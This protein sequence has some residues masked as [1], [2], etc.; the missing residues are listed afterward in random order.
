MGSANQSVRKVDTTLLSEVTNPTIYNKAVAT[1]NTEVSQVL[2]SNVK[3]F[4]VRCRESATLKLAY[5]S[6]ESGTKFITLKPHTVY[7]EEGLNATSLTLFLQSDVAGVTVEI[8][9]WA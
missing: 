9:E 5:N 3:R 4:L 8:V 6:G 2:S 7:N 1:A